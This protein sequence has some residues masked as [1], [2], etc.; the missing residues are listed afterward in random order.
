MAQ[1]RF[2][3]VWEDQATLN[4]DYL[5]TSWRA[6]EGGAV[7]VQPDGYDVADVQEV[8]VIH[9]ASAE[10]LRLVYSGHD[11]DPEKRTLRSATVRLA[12]QPCAYGGERFLFLAPCCGRRCRALALLPERVACRGCGSITYRSK[13]KS[14]VPRLIN[15][16]DRLARRLGCENWWGPVTE[17]PHAMKRE[18]FNR[19][20][21]EHAALV[22][23]AMGKIQP[24]LARASQR[25]PAA[26]FGAMIRAGL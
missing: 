4:A 24:R 3:R 21:D 23:Q 19:L 7:T 17:R 16:A 5:H 20:A 1:R 11:G 26:M 18:T 6:F 10:T 13:R 15:R 8:E 12:R 9:N 25:G 14:G 2:Q 22:R